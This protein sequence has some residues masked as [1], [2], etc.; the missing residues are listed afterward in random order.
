MTQTVGLLGVPTAAGAHSPGIEKAPAAL[1]AAGL[2]ERLRAAGL[3]VE[4]HGDL[5]VTRFRMDREHRTAQNAGL[6]ADVARDVARHTRDVLAAGEL[7]LIVGGDCTILI[8]ALA[9]FVAEGV[10]VAAVYLDGH[11][12]LNTPAGVAQGALDWMG[13]AHVLGVPGSEPV[14]SELGPRVPLLTWD[15]VAFVSYIATEVTEA[16]QALLDEHRPLAYEAA[17]V[18]GHGD[19]VAGE[20]ASSLAE[21]AETFLVHFDVD[22]LDFVEFPIADNAYV[23]NMGLTLVGAMGVL[24]G[25]TASPA[26]GGLVVTQVNPDHAAG[27]GPLLEEFGDRLA[28]SLALSV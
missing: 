25:L 27:Q 11:P 23:R 7:P 15:K 10:D 12:D 1:R 2:V 16:E 28:A 13:M 26:F 21:R 5:P 9:G 4:D 14:L 19:E 18:A 6:V 8:G 24:A 17:A 22:V 3:S 20:V